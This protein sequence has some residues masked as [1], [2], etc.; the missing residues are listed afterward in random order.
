MKYI[1]RDFITAS[2]TLH[3]QSEPGSA[4]A[5]AVY[6]IRTLAHK[7]QHHTCKSASHYVPSCGGQITNGHTI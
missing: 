2:I 3:V 5:N 7:L 4:C 6:Y 1:D